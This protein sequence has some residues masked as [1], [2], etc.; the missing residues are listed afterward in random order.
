[1]IFKKRIDELIVF[2]AFILTVSLFIYLLHS[3]ML[4]TNNVTRL[5]SR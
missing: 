5:W 1:M 3:E 2:R 4:E